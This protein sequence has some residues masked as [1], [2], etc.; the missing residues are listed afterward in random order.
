[1][2]NSTVVSVFQPVFYCNNCRETQEPDVEFIPQLLTLPPPGTC[3]ILPLEPHLDCTLLKSSF[4]SR[5][6]TWKNENVSFQMWCVKRKRLSCSS[7]LFQQHAGW[8]RTFLWNFLFI[9]NVCYQ[10]TELRMGRKDI[11]SWSFEKTKTVKRV[12]VLFEAILNKP[13]VLRDEK[14]NIRIKVFFKKSA[15]KDSEW[16]IQ[17]I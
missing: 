1:M 8:G 14:L 2:L 15:L 4:W 3:L 5:I 7:G 6:C 17:I 12:F 11:N 10:I 16:K 9:W 13:L